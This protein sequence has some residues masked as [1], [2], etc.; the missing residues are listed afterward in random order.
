MTN[1]RLGGEFEI[2]NLQF[3]IQKK[4]VLPVCGAFFVEIGN[5]TA[6]LYKFIKLQLTYIFFYL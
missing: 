1:L 5:S 6:P 3:E 2:Y 4:E